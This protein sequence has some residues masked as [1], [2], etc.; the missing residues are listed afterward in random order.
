MAQ[1]TAQDIPDLVKGTL[2]DL[3]PAKFNQIAQDIQY[4]EVF[5]KW[6][7]SDKVVFDSGIGVQRSLMARYDSSAAAH[8]TFQAPDQVNIVDVMEQIQVP[9]RHARASWGI[10]YQTDVLMNR[11]KAL[12]FNVIKPRRMSSL[13]SLAKELEVRAWGSPPSTTDK[14][15]PYGIQYWLTESATTGFNGSYPSGWTSIAGV[16]LT[17]APTFKNYT[18][19]YVTANKTDL[20]AKMRTAYRHTGFVSPLTDDQYRGPMGQRFRIYVNEPLIQDFENVGEG[21]N[22]N[23]G[24][25]IASMDGTV[26]FRKIPIRWIPILDSRTDNPV[27]MVDHST[28]FPMCLKGDY[29]RESE[30]RQN[31]NNHNSYDVFIDLTYNFI[32]DNRR[33]NAVLTTG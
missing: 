26:T 9:W 4:F 15:L 18:A 24:K 28:F 19:Q 33:Q 7:K 10:V 29:L 16:D 12:V 11:G 22:E 30:A 5:S 21:Q 13:L 31:P 27:Y 17:N 25:D 6:F 20:I 3:G 23:L 1:L 8:V 2:Y 32:C 14:V